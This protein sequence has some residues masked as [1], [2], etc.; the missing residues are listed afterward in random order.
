LPYSPCTDSSRGRRRDQDGNLGVWLKC[1]GVVTQLPPSIGNG[2][3]S[4]KGRLGFAHALEKKDRG[5]PGQDGAY[6]EACQDDE[7]PALSTSIQ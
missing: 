5:T 1:A 3:E 4:P 6:A 2:Q 7:P